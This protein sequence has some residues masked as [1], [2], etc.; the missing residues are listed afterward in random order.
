M[1]TNVLILNQNYEPLTVCSV[2]KAVVMMY[3]GKAEMIE[4]QRGKYVRS[5]TKRFPVPSIVRLGLY[6]RVPYRVILSRKNVL[7]RDNYRCQYC[8]L[9][10]QS[11]TIDHVVPKSKQGEDTWENLVAACVQCN[12]RKGDR[13]PEDARMALLRKPMRPNHVFFIRHILGTVDDGWKPYLYMQ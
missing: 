13:T 2:E 11:L 5:V 3:L 4:S 12:N 8:G 6:I 10:G 7:R 1:H 9:S